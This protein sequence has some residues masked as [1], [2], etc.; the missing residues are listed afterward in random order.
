[1]F[2]DLAALVA[3]A[4][5]AEVVAISISTD[6]VKSQVHGV[7][8]ENLSPVAESAIVKEVEQTKLP[9]V[10]E[11]AS[12]DS[13]F[14]NDSLVTEKP[15]LR[16]IAAM[17]LIGDDGDLLGILLVA[18]P[19]IRG[20]SPSQ[21]QS[22]GAIQKVI[23]TKIQLL[24]IL[25]TQH[26]TA[27]DLRHKSNLLDLTR[28]AIL[29]RDLEHKIV[30]WNE[31][32]SRIYGWTK[33]EAVGKN[34]SELLYEDPEDFSAGMAICIEQGSWI[35]EIRHR[36]KDGRHLLVECRWTLV[37]DEAGNPQAILS[38]KTDIT[39]RREAEE[40]IAEKQN[41]LQM[42]SRISRIGAWSVEVPSMK[43]VWSDEIK[44]IFEVD[45]IS[46]TGVEPQFDTYPEPGRSQIRQL[47]QECV[48]NGA[49]FDVE[50]PFVSPKGHHLWVR[51]VAEAVRDKSG[52]IVK[53]QGAIQDLTEQKNAANSLAASEERFRTLANA[54]PMIVWTATSEGEIDY[55]NQ[56]FSTY[57]GIAQSEPA[58][59]RWQQTLHPDDLERCFEEWA[60]S[61]R[62][63]TPY[64]IEYRLKENKSGEFRWFLVQAQPV[65][66]AEGQVIKWYGTGI[67]IH[68]TKAL[69]EEATQLAH[70]LST[71]L[72]SITDG[73]L[74]MDR[75]WR[76][77]YVNS[78]AEY[79]LMTSREKMLGQ[80]AW[81]LFPEAI[82]SS[83]YV[84]YHKAVEQGS[85]ISFEEYFPPI[86][87]WLD[88]H[89]YPSSEGLAVHFRDISDRK[90]A[91]Q[92]LEEQKSLLTDAQRIGQMGSYILNL[93]TS[94]LHW[95]ESFGELIGRPAVENE[96][97]LE[98]FYSF[99][100][101]EDREKVRQVT[102]APY[103]VDEA[104]EN[105]FRIQKPNG[106]I[107]WV[108]TRGTTE[109]DAAGKA[110]RRLGLMRD[111]TDQ[112]LAAE[113][114]KR[115]NAELEEMVVKRTEQLEKSNH[116]LLIAKE[117]AETANL[118]KSTFLSRMSHE[119]RTP[120]NAILGFGQLLELSDLDEESKD[121]LSHIL[122]AGRHLLNLIN[123][124]LEISRVEIGE[125]GLSLEPV[126]LLELLKECESLMKTISRDHEIAITTRSEASVYVMA[127]RQKLR[128]VFLN[129]ISNGI[130]YNNAGG[131]VTISVARVED[132]RVAISFEDTGIGISE[133][134][135]KRLFL[136]FERLGI[137][138]VEGTGLGLSL[139]RSLVE[140]MGG[141]M[142]A[143][144]VEGTGSTFVVELRDAVEEH[145]QMSQSLP[146]VTH[147]NAWNTGSAKILIIED[148]LTNVA[149]LEKLFAAQ[150]EVELIIAMQGRL[151][152]Q[153]AKKHK[154]D[155]VLLDLHLPDINGDEV[156]S[157]L[158]LDEELKD[159][160]VIIMSA[161]AFAHR[162]ESLL[163]LGAFQYVTKP[164]ILHDLLQKVD[165]ALKI[166]RGEHAE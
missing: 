98:E 63:S 8:L 97:S 103:R 166:S 12:E 61:L 62:D 6:V 91:L 13:R 140:A 153:L 24:N 100:V 53:V 80:V 148:N 56:Y 26:Q 18:D 151:G 3:E 55:S 125:I 136:P 93:Q 16:F 21:V 65:F 82:D 45:E 162:A 141:Q 38:T 86:D 149:L 138:D 44:R 123:D 75:E 15:F 11:N 135:M 73:F 145:A 99:V 58:G 106:E 29:V 109:F 152:L 102:V 23:V 48:S 76:F 105:Q 39:E 79:L 133:S 126:E 101:P 90:Q 139:S 5:G 88:L 94:T 118:F 144:S 41:V 14:S 66:G 20:L 129:V 150:P 89:A 110:V 74:T 1:M 60:I 92:K 117:S 114:L 78:E 121:S 154:P 49:S 156:I 164:F 107:R 50:L 112:Q 30:Y 28:D 96:A 35:G 127:D 155:L 160:P 4:C 33:E 83:F 131:S 37:R 85:S 67:D 17:P 143:T 163:E 46:T 10:I 47:F 134:N 57:T 119:L 158:K 122:K 147:S 22:L 116:E 72:E 71:T 2:D 27:S 34:I 7:G 52:A 51:V 165:L 95:S 104:L 64:E 137:G 157:L 9:V 124:V 161:D 142:S 36:A 77:T 84:N 113:A 81:E 146:H 130:K 108:A 59:S 43:R 32:A 159:I 111:I 25:A 69:Q 128:Q 132:D 42:A 70:S 87:R 40:M 31:G 19:D 115:T 120:M 54:M 68:D